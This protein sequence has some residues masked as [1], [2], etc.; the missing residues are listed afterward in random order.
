M[1][2]SESCRR[3]AARPHSSPLGHTPSYVGPQSQVLP[4]C[5]LTKA[6][7]EKEELVLRGVIG[8]DFK[9]SKVNRESRC[10]K[11]AFVGLRGG[12]A[13][14]VISHGHCSWGLRWEGA[15]DSA[16]E[17]GEPIKCHRCF[18]NR[19][20]EMRVMEGH[21]GSK[22]LPSVAL[23]PLTRRELRAGTWTGVDRKAP[24][25]TC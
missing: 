23:C 21:G 12:E 7:T 6:N 3:P 20:P 24:H 10:N 5:R 17:P 11:E 15:P 13:G 9:L 18:L 2:P 25:P 19:I 22:W 8:Q 16:H 4:L 1:H 14:T